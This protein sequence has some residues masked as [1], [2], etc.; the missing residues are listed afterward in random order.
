MT[1]E[2]RPATP[3][4]LR[5]NLDDLYLSRQAWRDAMNTVVSELPD[6]GRMAARAAESAQALADALD[7][8]SR[9]EHELARLLSYASLLSSED[10][11]V[12]SH[13]AMRHEV[14]RLVGAFRVETA[15]LEPAIVGLGRTTIVTFIDQE[16]RLRNHAVY[17]EDVQRRAAHVLTAA[18]ERLLA[19]TGWL[20]EGIPAIHLVLSEIELPAPTITLHD[21][22][23]VE[24]DQTGYVQLRATGH[25]GDRSRA[26]AAYFQSL[27][28]FRRAF[29]GVMNAHLQATMF[30]ADSRG[31]RTTLDLALDQEHVPLA[32]YSRLLAF[33]NRSLP[34]FHRYLAVRKRLLGA[35]RLNYFDLWAPLSGQQ[36]AEYSID[37]AQHEIAAS[38][39]P[40][41]EE[42]VA[43][44]RR[45]FAERWIDFVPSKGK[46]SGA[47]AGSLY[48]SHPYASVSYFGR[49]ADMSILAHELGHVAHSVYSNAAQPP[50]VATPG[51]QVAE[52]ASTLNQELLARHVVN[53]STRARD[54]LATLVDALDFVRMTFFRQAQFAEFERRMHEM[55]AGGPPPTAEALG[56]LHLDVARRYHG[57]DEGHCLVDDCVADEWIDIPHFYGT[58]SV[59]QYA[60]AYVAAVSLANVL[61]D[62]NARAR[63]RYL[64]LLAAGGSRYPLDLLADAGVDLTSDEPYEAAIRHIADLVAQAEQAMNS[65]GAV[66]S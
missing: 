35:E 30:V 46:P 53:R 42:Y 37:E 55:A 5:W 48:D 56:T 1:V 60:T 65:P 7:I 8:R 39:S 19:R 44:V 22:R 62:D 9:M 61:T 17:L 59:Y 15:C 25:A 51:G 21:G 40:L 26:S 52:V 13:R 27:G 6:V 45:A 28:A 10:M 50:Q 66:A 57:H 20:A 33:V 41:G 54:R 23:D 18:E 63:D 16:P 64:R 31:Y 49:Y 24:I 14:A 43:V 32:V 58:F 2:E 3:D 12:A 36:H 29:A 38:V 47:F 34:T 11:R 4:A